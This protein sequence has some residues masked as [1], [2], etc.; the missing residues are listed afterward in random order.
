VNLGHYPIQKAWDRVAKMLFPDVELV[1][2]F[3]RDR[4]L[5]D[6]YRP[7]IALVGGSRFWGATP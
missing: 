6:R 7:A 3:T 5:I 1:K 2:T 4:W